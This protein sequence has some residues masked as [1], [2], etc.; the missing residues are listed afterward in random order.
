MRVHQICSAF[1]IFSSTT[2][3]SFITLEC[4]AS[5]MNRLQQLRGYAT[6][7]ADPQAPPP[8]T[9]Y[10]LTRIKPSKVVSISAHQS[11]NHSTALLQQFYRDVDYVRCALAS[12]YRLM[13]E[14]ER[15]QEQRRWAVGNVQH[16]RYSNGA[17][18]LSRQITTL[19][20][21]AKHKLDMM[22]K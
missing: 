18:E 16:K 10:T 6:A 19:A 4:V 14:L 8:L 22:P 12:I 2:F 7:H 20:M 1:F 21:E 15:V 3:S 11:H 9:S 5:L 13:P 17:L